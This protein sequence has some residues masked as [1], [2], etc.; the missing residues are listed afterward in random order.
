MS[1]L[2]LNVW[3]RVALAASAV[4]EWLSS[5]DEGAVSTEYAIIVAV[6]ALAALAAF[7]AFGAAVIHAVQSETGKL[8]GVG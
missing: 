7:T 4:G 2:V 8:Q 6:V 3:V 1:S 5:E